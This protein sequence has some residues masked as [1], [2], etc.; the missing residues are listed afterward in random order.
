MGDS[1]VDRALALPELLAL[2]LDFLEDDHLSLS[3]AIRVNTFWNEHGEKV[4]W[5]E[6]P[7]RVLLHLPEDR[8]QKYANYVEALAFDEGPDCAAHAQYAK[9]QF[10]QLRYVS[11]DTYRPSGITPWIRQYLQPNLREFSFYGGD[12]HD[13]IRELLVDHCPRLRMLLIDN[14]GSDVPEL[15]FVE[16]LKHFRELDN[17]SL[18]YSK[19]KNVPDDVFC[20]LAGLDSLRTLALQNLLPGSAVRLMNETVEKPFRHLENLDLYTRASLL[21]AIVPV[22]KGVKKLDLKINA[23]T[24]LQV[25]PCISPLQDLE[26]LILTFQ[27][28]GGIILEDFMCLKKFPKLRTLEIADYGDFQIPAT[29]ETLNNVFK[30]LPFLESLDLAA[31]FEDSTAYLTALGQN[32]R[33]LEEC[34]LGGTFYLEKLRDVPAPLFPSLGS[35][36]LDFVDAW[37]PDIT[38]QIARVAAEEI[39]RHAPTL[40]D[41]VIANDTQ[42]AKRVARHW[43]ELSLHVTFQL[44]YARLRL[45]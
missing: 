12:A 45:L 9:L 20:H 33:N 8:R 1:A 26:V 39:R 31:V 23:D 37:D 19:Y 17:I 24:M 30:C 34:S 38:G 36:E 6:P 7:S 16:F 18:H 28:S 21:P 3:S 10:P 22:I 43:K 27:F 15:G 42:Y 11:I 40:E 14:I 44:G 41:L 4:L 35:L 5:R 25:I 32:C 13:D 29:I 2:I